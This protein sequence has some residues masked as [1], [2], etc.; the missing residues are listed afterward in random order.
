MWRLTDRIVRS[1]FVMAWRLATSP[2]RISLFFEKPDDR[3]GR[4]AALGVRDD[5]GL[6]GLQDGDHGVRGAEV[7]PYCSCHV[8][9]SFSSVRRHAPGGRSNA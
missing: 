5:D 6:A 4:A 1:G 7:D 3:R 9:V 2:T 8:G